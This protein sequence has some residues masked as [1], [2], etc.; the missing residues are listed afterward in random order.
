V[1]GADRPRA[2]LA[3]GKAKAQLSRVHALGNLRWQKIAPGLDY[4]SLA[5]KLIYLSVKIGPSSGP[6]SVCFYASGLQSLF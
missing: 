4:S 1:G 3:E 6:T 2:Q 5:K